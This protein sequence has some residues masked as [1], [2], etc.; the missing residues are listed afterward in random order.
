MQ[1]AAVVGRVTRSQP[2]CARSLAGNRRGRYQ[3]QACMSNSN[4]DQVVVCGGGIIGVATAY[5]LTLQG[6]KPTLV[7]RTGVASGASG[8]PL[9]LHGHPVVSTSSVWCSLTG[10]LVHHSCLC[11]PILQALSVA[12]NRMC[13]RQPLCTFGCCRQGWRVFSPILD[14]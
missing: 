5:Y 13:S 14:G 8:E 1:C 9:P 11:A 7:E 12:A 4:T 10:W 3:T 6:V 2:G